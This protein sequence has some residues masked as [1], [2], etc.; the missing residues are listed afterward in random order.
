MG[1]VG[2]EIASIV[3][4]LVATRAA[5]K[6]ARRGGERMTE[7]VRMN[8]PI[9]PMQPPLDKRPRKRARGTLRASWFTKPVVPTGTGFESGTATEDPI[10]PYVE[11][12]TR[13]HEIRPIPPNRRLAFVKDGHWW[14]PRVV[15]HP[16]THGQAMLRIGAA[17]V[18]DE[19]AHGLMD[20]ELE[21]WKRETEARL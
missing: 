20:R 1:Y 17:K 11:W 13:P 18:E 14:Y 12:N 21:A 7:L 4:P 10:A 9:A 2:G 3:K 19:L 6:M 5:E 8:T 15:H 16:G